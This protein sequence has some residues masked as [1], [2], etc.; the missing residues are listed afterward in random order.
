ML[1]DI[2]YNGSRAGGDS[3]LARWKVGRIRLLGLFCSFCGGVRGVM[4]GSLGEERRGERVVYCVDGGV[5]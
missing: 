1:L 5:A 2:Q 3:L 4:M